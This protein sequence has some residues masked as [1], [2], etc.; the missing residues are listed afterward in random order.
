[1]EHLRLQLVG[2]GISVRPGHTPRGLAI[3]LLNP[4]AHPRA[5]RAHGQQ[6][7]AAIENNPKPLLRVCCRSLTTLARE[8]R[9][10]AL[11]QRLVAVDDLADRADLGPQ[12]KDG[13]R[14]LAS[15]LVHACP[16]YLRDTT[17]NALP[18]VC[19]EI[20]TSGEDV[21]ATFHRRLDAIPIISSTATAPGRSTHAL[22]AALSGQMLITSS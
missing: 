8:L 6:L 20:S 22:A 13:V 15:L 17:I 21:F 2:H 10:Y 3:K 12:I 16:G 11:D 19:G 9:L 5:M 14:F 1:M 18:A 7:I 4:S